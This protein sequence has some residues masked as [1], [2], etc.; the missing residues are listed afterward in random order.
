MPPTDADLARLQ[1]DLEGAIVTIR[2]IEG[3]QSPALAG[4]VAE[5]RDLRTKVTDMD[6]HGTAVTRE[7]FRGIEREMAGIAE[8]VHEVKEILRE[9]ASTKD[10]TVVKEE[11]AYI[12]DEQRAT[13]A[14]VRS[15]LITAGLSIGVQL[16]VGVVLW[17]VL[18]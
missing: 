18:H 11:V 6:V 10:V 7:R 8:D 12:R 1:R 5:F 14:T 13:R 15:A 3:L 9:K 17:V 16:I 4:H 2:Q